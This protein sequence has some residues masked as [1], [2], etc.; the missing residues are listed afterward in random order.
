M[1]QM[2]P[3]LQAC[4]NQAKDFLL[5]CQHTAL[6]WYIQCPVFLYE[7]M[8]DLYKLSGKAVRTE[9]SQSEK[10]DFFTFLALFFFH[11]LR[12][13]NWHKFSIDIQ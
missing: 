6:C 2:V 11:P 9:Y 5:V 4:T 7:E 1:S 12:F 8:E 13:Y 10:K 3:D